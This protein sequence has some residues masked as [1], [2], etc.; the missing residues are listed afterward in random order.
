[1]WQL[2]WAIRGSS[3]LNG[4][5]NAGSR[6]MIQPLDHRLGLLFRTTVFCFLKIT[7]DCTAHHEFNGPRGET[8]CKISGGS[9]TKQFCLYLHFKT[10]FQVEERGN[11]CHAFYYSFLFLKVN[12]CIEFFIVHILNILSVIAQKNKI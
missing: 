2:L 8:Q 12:F 3:G 6:N 5:G 11:G 10:I 9:V 1:M 4:P 7:P